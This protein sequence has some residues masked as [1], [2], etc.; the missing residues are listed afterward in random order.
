[1]DL[2]LSPW[3]LSPVHHSM[4]VVL[5]DLRH[6]LLPGQGTSPSAWDRCQTIAQAGKAS[7][8]AAGGVGIFT[9]IDRTQDARFKV[10]CVDK[11]PDAGLKRVN[12][13]ARALNLGFA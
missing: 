7:G 8:D 1:M 5:N 2:S 12:T 4:G 11:A 3:D 10:G 9:Q 13:V 6:V